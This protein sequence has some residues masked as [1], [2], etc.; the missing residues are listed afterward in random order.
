MALQVLDRGQESSRIVA[1]H[2]EARIALAAKKFA[3]CPGDVAM[4]NTETFS[5]TAYRAGGS[6]AVEVSVG[7]S[8]SLLLVDSPLA[9]LAVRRA[10]LV[11]VE[12]I[13]RL[14]RL[15]SRASTSHCGTVGAQQM[16][17][18]LARRVDGAAVNTH[19]AAS[20]GFSNAL[21]A[22]RGLAVGPTTMNVVEL[23]LCLGL[24]AHRALSKIGHN[25]NHNSEIMDVVRSA[26]GCD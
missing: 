21:L 8:V 7:E 5:G 15:A 10:F 1:E 13:S 20:L 24:S 25:D 17:P 18:A 14:E 12:L 6:E 9:R 19:P 3:R 16:T 23:V 4:V 26:H 11:G 22:S 2:A